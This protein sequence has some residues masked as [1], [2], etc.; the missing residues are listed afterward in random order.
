[1]RRL[2]AGLAVVAAAVGIALGGA[3]PAQALGDVVYT[4]NCPGTATYQ[5]LVIQN[6]TMDIGIR[7]YEQDTFHAYRLVAS[8]SAVS[9]T[10][11][12]G[13]VAITYVPIQYVDTA[14]YTM[15]YASTYNWYYHVDC[16]YN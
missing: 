14:T 16:F 15:R 11:P 10:A 4:A 6:P 12:P 7:V 8:V 9:Q 13:Y 1:M 2:L 5:Q 3:A